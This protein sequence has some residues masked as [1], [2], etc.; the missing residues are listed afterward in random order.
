MIKIINNKEGISLIILLITIAVI[1]ILLTTITF[2][3]DNVINNT[4]KR[5]FAKEIYEVQNLVDKYK[6]ENGDYPYIIENDEKKTITINVENFF[7]VF[8]SEDITD[9]IVTLYPINLSKAGIQNLSRGINKNN[10]SNDVY[11]ISNTTGIV[12]YVKGYKV[13]NN[14]YY[15][16]TDELK[17]LL[18][19][20]TKD[21]NNS[22]VTITKEI[23]SDE[24]IKDGLILHYDG[25]NNIRDGN[26]AH[27]TVWEDLSGNNNDGIFVNS[28]NTIKYIGNGYEFTNNIDYIETT[29]VL[30]LSTDP[31]ITLEIVYKWYGMQG[32]QTIAGLFNFRTNNSNAGNSLTG[33][34]TTDGVSFDAINVSVAA[35]EPEKNVVNNISFLKKSGTFNTDTASIYSN[36]NKASI[37]SSSGTTNMNLQ[38]LTMQIGRGWQYS[39]NRT[40]NGVIYAVRVYNRVLS[41]EEIKHN[42]EIDKDRFNF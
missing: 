22:N 16:L 4:K 38:N 35:S 15:N 25:I 6:V 34:F 10:N 23:S 42:Y 8:G 27:S 26:N 20:K 17:S 36:S 41:E 32:N 40:L 19:F 9:N 24:Y 37:I 13:G 5:Q 28:N 18:G 1:L 7:D 39:G 29:N 3:V 31:N 14:T 11:A 33:W 30:S 2:S 21:S 12:Y